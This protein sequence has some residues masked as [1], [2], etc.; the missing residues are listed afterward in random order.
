MMAQPVWRVLQGLCLVLYA[1]GLAALAGWWSGAGAVLCGRASV[2]MLAVHLLELVWARRW[3][4]MYPGALGV[5]VLL[6]VLFG[7]LH[8]WP[9]KARAAPARNADGA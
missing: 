1:L 6:T 3:V 5:S 4:A 2:A 9:L 8:W 7:A